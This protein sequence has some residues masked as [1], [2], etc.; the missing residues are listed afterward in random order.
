ME[1]PRDDLKG[2]LRAGSSASHSPDGP[3]AHP[4]LP[5]RKAI[6]TFEEG[7]DDTAVKSLVDGV[8]GDEA[9]V[10]YL[11]GLDEFGG[12]LPPIHDEVGGL[13][14][15]AFPG[16]A[17][18]F[19]VAV[20]EGIAHAGGS[21][22]GRVAD[23]DVGLGPFGAA[24][25]GVVEDG[26]AGAVVGDFLAGD[27]VGLGGVAVPDGDDFAGGGVAARDGGIVGEDG[28]LL[29]DGGGFG[30]ERA[31]VGI[32]LAGGFPLPLEEAD[33]EDE[34]GDGDGAAV[35]FE[36]EELARANLEAGHFEGG[37][38]AEVFVGFEDFGFEALHEFE[39][40]VEEVSGAAGGIEDAEG[41]DFPVEIADG[42][43][44]FLAVGGGLFEGFLAE[45]VAGVGLGFVEGLDVLLGV[46][47]DLSGGGF[48][49][50]R[51]SGGEGGGGFDGFPLVA[52]GLDEGGADEALNVGAGGVVGAELVALAGI[53]GAL[54]E[55]AKDGGL[56]GGPVGIRGVDEEG[57]LLGAEREGGGVL[58]E[59]A[60]EM[61]DGSEQED[62]E[63]RA[64][65]HVS[66]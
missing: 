37:V 57:D 46:F 9:E 1:R 50:G 11:A 21:D 39:R 13:G 24:G 28:V 14:D 18:G 53:E 26:F 31:L 47:G 36:A 8:G 33:P 20:A 54:D 58:E 62:G 52:K 23:D 49:F 35:E 63:V 66:P 60:V 27:G 15:A 10:F 34:L 44:G 5:D 61:R 6:I 56:D 65:G 32:G 42:G 30:E 25:V 4:C 7:L 59:A 29:E 45:F 41:A 43:E 17:Q 51:F 55:G 2:F 3:E 12:F 22:E 19:R 16:F 48:G 64:R 40:D 38:A